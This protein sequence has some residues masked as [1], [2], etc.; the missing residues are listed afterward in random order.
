MVS[1]DPPLRLTIGRLIYGVAIVTALIAGVAPRLREGRIRQNERT[2]IGTLRT[3]STSQAAFQSSAIVDVDADGTGEFGFFHELA[4]TL[5]CRL[6]PGK[7][8]P[9]WSPRPITP[10]FI[11]S[12]LGTTAVQDG[13]GIAHKSGYCFRMYLPTGAGPATPEPGRAVPGTPADAD[14][15]ELRFACYAWPEVLG[16]SGRRAFVVTQQG[17]VF[18]TRNVGYQDHDGL[19]DP[20]APGAAL[21]PEPGDDPANLE[22]R[23]IQGLPTSGGFV[24][25]PVGP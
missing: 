24:W 6:P 3:L 5:G 25:T 7:L 20:P 22:G 18:A 14:A 17:V 8:P 15:Q 23:I 10:P 21:L 9:G 12:I 4:G 2:A 19:T 16:V 1:Q 13:D 11:R